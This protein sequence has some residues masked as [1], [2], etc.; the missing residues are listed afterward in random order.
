MAILAPFQEIQVV[1]SDVTEEAKL[2]PAD[3]MRKF[4]YTVEVHKVTTEDGYILEVDRI[5]QPPTGSAETRR[6]AILLVHGILANAVT[7]VANLPPQSPGFL[8]SDAGFDVWFINSRGVPESNFHE[9]LTTNDPE[10]WQW[11]FDEIGRYDLSAVIDYILNETQLSNISLLTTSRGF[12]SSVV[13]L[14][15]RPEYND[16]VNILIG[17]APV[18][19]IT[20][21]TSPLRLVAPFAGPAKAINDLLTRGGFLVSSQIQKNLIATACNSP[22][23]DI[24]YAPLAVL[25]GINPKQ[26]NK[27]RIPVY[28]ANNPVGT[29]SQELVHYAQVYKTKNLVRYDYGKKENQAR[30]GQDAPPEYPL[31][32]IRVPL[33]VFK[34]RADIF[35][36]P[37]D[38]EDLIRRLRDVIVIDYEVPD[39][40]FG[41]LDF[42]YGFNATEIL[43]RPMIEVL[44]NYT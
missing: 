7:W 25:F 18:A 3:L 37:Q 4:G 44:A 38:V 24:C 19:N 29:S 12:T 2:G 6:P 34:G 22:L 28:V 15:L 41:H 21:F 31:E 20:Y 9:T 13:L 10:F 43:H 1:A 16:K 17:Y 30:Y 33:A 32:N 5:P 39:T 8:L 26:L 40:D 11:S 42:I 27:T 36:D 35:A 14:S 23:R